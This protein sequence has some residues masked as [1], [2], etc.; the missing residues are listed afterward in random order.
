MARFS[1]FFC[2]AQEA[3]IVV[4]SSKSAKNVQ[5]NAN[6][7]NDNGPLLALDDC[8][9]VVANPPRFGDCVVVIEPQALASHV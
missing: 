1:F 7:R 3:Q 2:F 9:V 4:Y 8:G 6:T 5:N